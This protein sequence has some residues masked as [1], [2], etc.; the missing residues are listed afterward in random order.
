[1]VTTFAMRRAIDKARDAGIGW[2]LIRNTTHQG[3]MGYYPLMAAREGMAGI[4][5]VNGPPSMAPFGAA[6]M[7]VHNTPVAICVPGRRRRP[8]LLDM[9]MSVAAGGK[10]RLAKDRGTPI[11]PGWTLDKHGKPTTDPH[12][13]SILLPIAGPKGS[14]LALMFECLT[15]LMV[16]DPLLEPALKRE[17]GADTHRQH[18]IVAAIDIAAFTGVDAY[19][20]HVDAIVDE[21]KKL[22]RAD[23]ATEILVPGELE[24]DTH[25]ERARNGIPLPAG[26]MQKLEAAAKRFDV[27]LPPPMAG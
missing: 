22:P 7:G 9:A 26:T 17:P 12:L 11:P 20:D 15:G 5:I 2:V 27:P 4:A 1:V 13:A 14:G 3:A 24:D 18:G 6:A 8:L 21:L 19:R 10:L 25:D 16:G 23:G